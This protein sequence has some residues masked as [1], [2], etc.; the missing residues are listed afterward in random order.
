LR[1]YSNEDEDKFFISFYNAQGQ[2]KKKIMYATNKDPYMLNMVDFCIDNNQNIV[3]VYIW[4]DK[5]GKIDQAGK[6][7]FMKSL[8]GIKKP[9]TKKS[10]FGEFPE[11]VIYK[12]IDIDQYGNLFI[13]GGHLSKNPSRDIYVLNP[14]GEY[15]CTFTL[16]ES[17]HTIYI[18]NENFLYSRANEGVTLK[19]YSIKYAL[20]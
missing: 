14:E 12:A 17:S 6:Q 3:I 7:I 2:I 19:K 10:Q 11:D 15:I 9:K 4:K 18:D 8:L 1:S 5:V 20:K 13:L 16:P